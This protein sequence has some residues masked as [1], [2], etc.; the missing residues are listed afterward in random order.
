MSQQIYVY[1]QQPENLKFETLGR[2]TVENNKGHWIY[3]PAYTGTWVPD[4]IHYPLRK[5]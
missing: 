5:N 1:I 3:S 2:L 4:E